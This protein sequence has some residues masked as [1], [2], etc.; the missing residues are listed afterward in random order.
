MTVELASAPA[1]AREASLRLAITGCGRIAERGY[2]P[3]AN[4]VPGISIAALA[5]PVPRRRDALQAAAT[6]LAGGRRPAAYES[7]ERLLAEER[8]DALVIATPTEVH[9][10]HAALAA[11][12]G[13][14]TLVEKPPASTL[15][16][17]TRLAALEPLPWIGF[18]RRF[19][20]GSGL[21]ERVRPLAD[22]RL[23][24]EIQYRRR[25]WDP[26]VARDEALLDAA[27]HGIDLALF[28]SGADP[29]A[30]RARR[31]DD[32]AAE[33]EVALDR[34]RALIR[35]SLHR[36]YRERVV[37]RDR[38]VWPIA[39]DDR[40]GLRRALATRVRAGEH[41]LVA[42]ISAQLAAFAR[43]V[44]GGD[45][46]PLASAADGV[47]VMRVV[48]AARRSLVRDRAWVSA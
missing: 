38:S 29:V 19:M 44:T 18:N 32:R 1:R 21:R 39:R 24:I 4:R 10:T 31:L 15:A 41:P 17:A 28:L 27:P 12:V 5:D 7:L 33:L 26:L 3:A 40:G 14:P 45:P 47:E 46:A 36:P 9:L 22:P 34:G 25:A 30:V 35:C 11:G 8:P 20:V 37:V 48:K 42:S 23:R 2:L 13:I 16:E 6:A 43:A